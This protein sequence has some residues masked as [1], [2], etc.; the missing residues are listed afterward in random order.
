M[1]EKVLRPKNPVEYTEVKISE[2]GISKADWNKFFYSQRYD[3]EG[4]L[5]TFRRPIK[6][7]PELEKK[8]EEYK[9]EK[10][11]W[12]AYREKLV[13]E[14]N[15]RKA[16][17]KTKRKEKAKLKEDIAKVNAQLKNL[18]EQKNRIKIR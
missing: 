2:E 11:K 16:Q 12:R 5:Q 8:R 3:K 7:T 18:R 9:I 6:L 15:V 10:K 1:T 17:R 14:K 13:A 4:V